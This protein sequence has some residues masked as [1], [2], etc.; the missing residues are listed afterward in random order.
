MKRVLGAV[1]GL[2]S[3]AAGEV[4]QAKASAYDAK[5]K[6]V[7]ILVLDQ[8]RGDYMDRYRA[9]FKTEDGFNLFMKRGA[10]FPNAY[11]EYSNTETAPGHATIGTCAYSDGHNIGV[12]EWWDLERT[13]T[14]LV[15]SVEDAAYPLVG[16]S[17]GAELG[18]S[19]RNELASTI[20]D[21][22]VE[23]T[24]GKAK[25]FGVSL[26]DRAAI[27]TS[28]HASRGAYW[29]DHGT[30]AWITSTYWRKDLPEWVKAFNAGK[31]PAEARQKAGAA[32]G[33]SFYDK[34]GRTPE[35]V[36]YELEFAKTLIEEEKLGQDGVTDLLTL[37]L[38]STDILGHA[39]GPDSPEQ[40]AMIDSVDGQLDGFFRWLDRR[41][42][43]GNV[44]VALTGDHGVAPSPV[45]A[46]AEGLPAGSFSS[47]QI[48]VA[49]NKELQKRLPGGGTFVLAAGMPYIHLD[50]DVFAKAGMKDEHAA[51]DLVASLLPSA[52][53]AT[54]EKVIA[55]AHE[56][57]GLTPVSVRHV[58]TKWGM[59]HNQLPPTEEGKLMANSFTTN[60]GWWIRWEPGV[61]QNT[62]MQGTTHFS[63]NAYDRHVPVAFFGP[64]FRPGAYLGHAEPVDISA[65]LAALLRVNKPSACVGRVLTE[66][67]SGNSAQ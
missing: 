67:I 58:Y 6:L 51:E 54:Q 40:R 3:L 19:P 31:E 38:S 13:R 55:A 49:L 48:A 17:T 7:V 45:A 1:C 21:E 28:G 20:G 35:G 36:A 16:A 32:A 15:S 2:L 11:Y 59:A 4:Q 33:E 30:G 57:G 10:Y 47:T 23:S 65:T 44:V 66:A 18:A 43:L 37:S 24:G 26:K 39:V 50:A 8:F 63:A 41:V 29:L 9:D 27:L 22:L 25:V 60:G 56:R 14:H 12:N 61:F 64:M 52:V 46:A 5:P 53:A 34:V 42:G 62:A